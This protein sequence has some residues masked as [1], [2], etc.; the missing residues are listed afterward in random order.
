MNPIAMVT[1]IDSAIC[2]HQ[3]AE[4]GIK[5]DHRIHGRSSG[6]KT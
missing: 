6:I 1:T 4:F 2:K 3:L 5:I